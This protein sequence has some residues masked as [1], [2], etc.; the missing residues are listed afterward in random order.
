MDGFTFFLVVVPVAAF[1][2]LGVVSG[3]VVSNY[4]VKE[5]SW[6]TFTVAAVTATV[7][8]PGALY[9]WHLQDLD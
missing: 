5:P 1:S 4:M 8:I 2:T 6:T 9:Y 3:Y 7:G